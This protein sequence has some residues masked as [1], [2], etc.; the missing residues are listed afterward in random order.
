MNDPTIINLEKNIYNDRYGDEI[1]K[2]TRNHPYNLRK[3]ELYWMLNQKIDWSVY[4][5]TVTFDNINSSVLSSGTEKVVMYEFNYHFLPKIRR[6]LCRSRK[7]WEKVLP[8]PEFVVYEY[9]QGSYFKPVPKSNSPHHIH[10]IFTVRKNLEA[11]IFDREVN[12]LDKRLQKDLNSI[13]TVGSYLIEPLR[14]DEAE[15]WFHYMIKGKTSKDLG[16]Y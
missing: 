5:I 7:H 8:T 12:L 11:K 14:L 10:G 1:I 15:N 4:T 9:Q 16:W 3:Q 13:K 2:K 6:R